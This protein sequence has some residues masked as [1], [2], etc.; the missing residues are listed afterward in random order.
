MKKN[1][2]EEKT[3]AMEGLVRL[4]SLPDVFDI[5]PIKKYL[6]KHSVDE[7]HEDES[8]IQ[9]TRSLLPQI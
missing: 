4:K 3:K 6:I 8:S 2:Y 5:A 1:N 7:D 9:Q